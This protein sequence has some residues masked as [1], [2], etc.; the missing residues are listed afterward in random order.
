[1]LAVCLAL[2]W[3]VMGTKAV[4][5]TIHRIW[6]FRW[7]WVSHLVY[8]PSFI[9]NMKICEIKLRFRLLQVF[10]LKSGESI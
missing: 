1:M 9:C 6:T 10:F 2:C 8:E 5:Q 4:S 3:S 7:P